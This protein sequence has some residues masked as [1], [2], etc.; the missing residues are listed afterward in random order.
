MGATNADPRMREGHRAI[1]WCPRG[2][3]QL[4]ECH[5]TIARIGSGLRA[6]SE[7]LSG[8]TWHRGGARVG[9]ADQ[10]PAVGARS[11]PRARFDA[12]SEAPGTPE[13][14][15]AGSARVSRKAT[16]A[17]SQRGIAGYRLPDRIAHLK[18]S[19]KTIIPLLAKRDANLVVAG[20]RFVSEKK[21]R[22]SPWTREI[23]FK[24]SSERA[25]GPGE[26]PRPGL[27]RVVGG[28][29]P[30]KVAGSNRGRL[31]RVAR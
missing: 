30:P 8:Y 2:G 19:P 1:T 29:K 13:A 23:P 7:T 12:W 6:G 22:P 24:L 15:P 17:D 16:V 18:G 31:S 14:R 3:D 11:A 28:A 9:K 25:L 5:Q 26:R 27:L 10:A 4:R 21:T 20:A